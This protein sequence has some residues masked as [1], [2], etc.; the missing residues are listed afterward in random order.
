MASE[1]EGAVIRDVEFNT[2]FLKGPQSFQKTWEI[3]LSRPI[4]RIKGVLLLEMSFWIGLIRLRTVV[5]EGD[6]TIYM[7]D[8]DILRGYVKTLPFENI[9]KTI[10]IDI[11]IQTRKFI[12]ATLQITLIVRTSLG[13]LKGRIVEI[14]VE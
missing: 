3:Q 13:S 5:K 6:F 2:D 7:H 4:T 12:Q 9:A 11:P 10:N 8:F 14:Q 1:G